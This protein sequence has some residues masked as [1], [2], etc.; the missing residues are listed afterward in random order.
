M[1]PVRVVSAVVVAA[2]VTVAFAGWT[3]D[4][5]VGGQAKEFPITATLNMR[6][7]THPFRACRGRVVL[8]TLCET[9]Y[10]KCGDAIPDINGIYDK[11]GPKGLTVLAYGAQ[12]RALVEKWISEKGVKFPWVLIDTATQEEFKREWPAPGM[13]WSY[14]IDVDGKIVWQENP[15]NMQNPG[16]LKPGT[17][18]PLLAAAWAPALLPK[19]LADQQKLLDDGTWAAAKKSLVDAASGG[20]LDKTDANWAKETAAWLDRRHDVAL[21]HADELCKKGWWWDAWDEMT[22][23]PHKWEGMDGADKAAAKAAEIEKTPDAEKDMTLGKD[24]AK[25]RSLVAAKNWTP[26]RLLLKRLTGAAKGTRFA[27]RVAELWE[28]VPAK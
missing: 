17:M 26:A 28:P 18:E 20:K 6:P 8:F 4:P 2:A 5:P 12:D 9:W 11:Y 3:T 25:A 14:L 7:A 23:F 24:V 13:P 27:D 21:A 16:V 19:A 1:R 10:E 15:R 22:D